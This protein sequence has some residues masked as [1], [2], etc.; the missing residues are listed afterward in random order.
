MVWDVV[1]LD[2]GKVPEEWKKYSMLGYFSM[3]RDPVAA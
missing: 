1:K 3:E 2:V